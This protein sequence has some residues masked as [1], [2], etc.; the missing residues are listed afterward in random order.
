[1]KTSTK[2]PPATRDRLIRSAIE[3]VAESGLAA[4]TTSAIAQRTGVAEG[5]LYRHFESKDDLLIAA[6]RQLKFEVFLQAGADVDESA[7]RR[8][9]G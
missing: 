4:A 8:P 3:I 9:S 1:M 7:P 2:S 5:T 6:Y